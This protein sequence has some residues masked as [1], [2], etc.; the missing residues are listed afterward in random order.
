[1]T[2]LTS[3][4]QAIL[5]RLRED[6]KKD[7]AGSANKRSHIVHADKFS[8]PIGMDDNGNFFPTQGNE[9]ERE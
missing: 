6:L 1:M 2:E 5:D 7:Q 8:A 9:Q 4:K 3:D